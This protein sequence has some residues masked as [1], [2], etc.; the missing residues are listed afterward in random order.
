[1]TRTV[2]IPIPIDMLTRKGEIPQGPTLLDEEQQ[3]TNGSHLEEKK[4]RTW[5]INFMVFIYF[6][7]WDRAVTYNLSSCDPQYYIKPSMMVY[8]CNSS[9]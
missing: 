2:T 9:T 3:A 7:T 1:M 6:K 8:A 4:R 5:G